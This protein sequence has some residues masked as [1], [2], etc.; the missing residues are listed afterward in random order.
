[1]Q[2][3][4]QFLDGSARVLRELFADTRNAVG[5]IGLVA[6]VDWPPRAVTMRV[7]DL[8]G[9]EV[10]SKMKDDAQS[11]RLRGAQDP[12]E[13]SVAQAP[14]MAASRAISG[15]S[16]SAMRTHHIRPFAALPRLFR[17]V[18]RAP[19]SDIDHGW[20]LSQRGS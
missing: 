5:A 19:I 8:D 2:F 18:K 9:R 11:W 14:W 15:R 1:M 12:A 13:V 20:R 3:R 4:V 10:H 7:L 17:Y 6:D 16:S